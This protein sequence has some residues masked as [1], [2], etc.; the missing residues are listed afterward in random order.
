MHRSLCA[1]I[2][3]ERPTCRAI[4]TP[5]PAAGHY[6]HAGRPRPR[7]RAPRADSAGQPGDVRTLPAAEAVSGNVIKL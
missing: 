4:T 7:I 5:G 6:P 1:V 2:V 3:T